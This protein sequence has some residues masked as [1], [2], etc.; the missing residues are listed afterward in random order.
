[1]L[2][3]GHQVIV[4]IIQWTWNYGLLLISSKYLC[5]SSKSKLLKNATQEALQLLHKML[6]FHHI[7]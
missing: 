2:H 7:S 1:M 4:L 6:K 5:I 3:V